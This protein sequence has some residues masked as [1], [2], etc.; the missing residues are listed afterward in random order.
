MGHSRESAFDGRGGEVSIGRSATIS[1]AI[2]LVVGMALVGF[3]SVLSGGILERLNTIVVGCF[4]AFIAG[5]DLY[6][7]LR[8]NLGHPEFVRSGVFLG[9][10]LIGTSLSLDTAPLSLL[11]TLDL[12]IGV[13][14]IAVFSFEFLIEF[15]DR[16]GKRRWARNHGPSVRS[17]VAGALDRLS[18]SVGALGRGSNHIGSLGRGSSRDSS[19]IAPILLAVP[20]GIGAGLGAAAFRFLMFLVHRAFFGMLLSVLPSRVWIAV[21][22]VLGALIAGVLIY[23]LAPEAAGHGVPENMEAIATNEGTIRHRLPPFKVLVSALTLGAGGS[24]GREG[25]IA[26]IGAGVGSSLG[27]VFDLSARNTRLLLAAGIAGGIGATFGAPIGGILFGIEIVMLYRIKPVSVLVLAETNL[28]AVTT[29]QAIA[30]H[31]RWFAFMP[32]PLP[33]LSVT[34][35]DVLY[36]VPYG[37]VMGGLAALWVVLLDRTERLF[38]K[39]DV[40]DDFKP[41]IGAIPVGILGI[42]FARYGVMGVGY[43]GLRLAVNDVTIGAGL[44]IALAA[45]KLIAT[46]FTIGSGGSGGVFAPTLYIGGLAAVGLHQVAGVLPISAS[47][48]GV[49]GMGAIFSGAAFAPLT[50]MFLVAEVFDSYALVLILAIPSAISYAI[51]KRLIGPS[52]YTSRLDRKGILDGYPEVVEKIGPGEEEIGEE[53][54]I[55][56]VPVRGFGH[57][58]D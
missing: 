9:L 1:S 57:S 26:R 12:C 4:L 46:Q 10:W 27:Q 8:G 37:I 14:A 30:P 36:A 55:D 38:G 39:V 16:P 44:L 19:Y 29:A 32:F 43:R 35:T 40:P 2:A 7:R 51:S 3:G 33:E 22:P 48:L 54:L 24:G 53:D 41:A 28:V 34:V 23:E 15:T 13:L 11:T 18:T 21:L 45:S 17:I 31:F 5:Y 52:I 58:S 25:P 20:V 49:V 56:R 42:Y 6:R 47:L 50:A